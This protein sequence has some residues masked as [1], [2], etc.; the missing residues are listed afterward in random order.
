MSETME[1]YNDKQWNK[2]QQK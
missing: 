1:L 2:K